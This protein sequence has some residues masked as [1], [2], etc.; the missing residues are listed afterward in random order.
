MTEAMPW[1]LDGAV[2][3]VLLIYIG[4]GIHRGAVRTVVEFVGFFAALV[5][6]AT[7]SDAVTSTLFQSAIRPVVQ[8]SMTNALEGI[9]AGAADPMTALMEKMPDFAVRY[10]EN[11]QLRQQLAQALTVSSAEGAQML[12]DNVVG[13]VVQMLLHGLISVVVFIVVMILIR[14]L[15]GA[16]DLVAK[17]PVLRQLNEGLGAICG[18]AKG[19]VIVMLLVTL[20]MAVLPF[21]P[22]NDFITAGHIEESMIFR[23][24]HEINP[25]KNWKEW[26]G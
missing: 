8:E 1:I 12:T 18:A 24:V 5:A 2:V 23:W 17:L 20:T 3:L 19:V 10:F 13:P 11:A 16:L 14:M 15:A 6:A 9:T 26:I 4:I 22:E 25:L 7:V 21:L